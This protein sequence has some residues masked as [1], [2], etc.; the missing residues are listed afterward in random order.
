MTDTKRGRWRFSLRTMFV[1]VTLLGVGFGVW[2]VPPGVSTKLTRTTDGV[3]QLDVQQ[4][5]KVNYIMGITL[6]DGGG[7]PIWSWKRG[8]NEEPPA[9]VTIRLHDQGDADRG[10]MLRPIRIGEPF[11]FEVTFQYDS[12]FAACASSQ[13]FHFRLASDGAPEY[14]GKSG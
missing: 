14:L 5:F 6:T 10:Q 7:A 8:L 13:Q 2:V 9:H 1:V 12:G 4:N 3:L 11:S